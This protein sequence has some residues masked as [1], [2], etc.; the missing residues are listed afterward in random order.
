MS[1]PERPT[2]VKRNAI[3]AVSAGMA[4]AVA[5]LTTAVLGSVDK[6]HT[7]TASGLNSAVARSG[8]LI[9]TALL[10]AVLAMRAEALVDEFHVAAMVGAALALASALTAFAFLDGAKP[11]RNAQ[12][13]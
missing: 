3:F 2:F 8:G 6:G 13:R 7:G 4:V 5:P 12:E 1:A 10:G 11:G 9:A